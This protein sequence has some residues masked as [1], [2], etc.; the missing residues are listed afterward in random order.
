[1]VLEGSLFIIF[2]VKRKK[3]DMIVKNSLFC[4]ICIPMMHLLG[5][6]PLGNSEC[7]R[8]KIILYCVDGTLSTDFVEMHH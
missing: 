7:S 1:M 6:H 3:L 8:V 4:C 5:V 2:S